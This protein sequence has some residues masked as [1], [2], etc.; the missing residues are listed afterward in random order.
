MT[1]TNRTSSAAWA[2][3]TI[4]NPILIVTALLEVMLHAQ[5]TTTASAHAHSAFPEP[6]LCPEKWTA[7]ETC[8]LDLLFCSQTL[9]E[10]LSG[11]ILSA[12]E[13]LR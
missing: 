7:I 9:A 3:V 1:W 11:F 4:L 13:G 12:E 10:T 5:P 2:R 8:W 6:I